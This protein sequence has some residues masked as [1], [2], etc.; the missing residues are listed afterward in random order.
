MSNTNLDLM[1]SINKLN[2]SRNAD[3]NINYEIIN[4]EIARAK[5]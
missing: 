2:K 1:C 5:Q 3:T 4:D